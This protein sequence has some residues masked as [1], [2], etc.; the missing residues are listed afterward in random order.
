MPRKEL[1]LVE[2]IWTVLYKKP[3]D[4]DIQ[5]T[6]QE[7]TIKAMYESVFA[8]WLEDPSL[9]DKEIVQYIENEFSRSQ[10]QAYRDI[11]IIKQVLG[12]IKNASKEWHRYMVIETLKEALAMAKRKNNYIGMIIAADKLG[13]YTKLDKEEAEEIPWADI[14]PPTFEPTDDITVLGLDKI[15][16]LTERRKQLEKRYLTKKI[17]IPEAEVINEFDYMTEKWENEHSRTGD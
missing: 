11:A 4:V 8:K 1:T 6:P 3:E 5:F 2:K 17:N 16:N 13:K 7:L 12:N 14:V 10:T 15:P 9:Q